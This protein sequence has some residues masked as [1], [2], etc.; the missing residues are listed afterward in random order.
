[1]RRSSTSLQNTADG[2]HFL[3]GGYFKP[4]PQAQG[5]AFGTIIADNHTVC[6]ASALARL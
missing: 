5:S 2:Q 1:M 3:T 6:F 4:G